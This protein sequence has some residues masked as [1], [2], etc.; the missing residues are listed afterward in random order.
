MNNVSMTL[1]PVLRK[2][3]LTTHITFSVG[4]FGA[5]AGFLA[6]AVAG[7]T[8]GDAQIVRS[9]YLSM[10][11]IGWFI[12]VPACLGALLSGIIQSLGTQWGLFQHYWVLVKLLLTIAATIILL[13]DMQPIGFI[14]DMVSQRAIS[15]S[16]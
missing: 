11:L 4:W 12:I 8:S 15:N 3:A 10:E 6:L 2:F 14:A 16:E 7:L 13:V 5:V 9:A 1:T